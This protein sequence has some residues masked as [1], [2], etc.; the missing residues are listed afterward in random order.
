MNPFFIQENFCIRNA[1][2]KER[3][4]GGRPTPCYCRVGW[5]AHC[6]CGEALQ[7]KVVVDPY[8]VTVERDESRIV[9]VAKLSTRNIFN[10]GEYR[11]TAKPS[12]GRIALHSECF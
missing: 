2:P 9:S 6:I 5:S 3:E 7:E 8:F 12:S 10:L 1:A 4:G 11:V